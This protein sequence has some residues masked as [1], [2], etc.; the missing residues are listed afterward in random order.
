MSGAPLTACGESGSED[1]DNSPSDSQNVGGSELGTGASS[2]GG[3]SGDDGSGGSNAGGSN[4]G[5]SNAGGT[6]SDLPLSGRQCRSVSDCPADHP[7]YPGSMGSVR[8]ASPYTSAADELISGVPP[9]PDW[10]GALDC[11]SLPLSPAAAGDEC[12]SDDDCAPPSED[13]LV[14]SLCREGTC[15]VCENNDDCDGSLPFC[16]ARSFRMLNTIASLLVCAACQTHDDCGEETPFCL[17]EEGQAPRC[18]ACL[19]TSDCASGAC[20][21]GSCRPDCT[22]DDDCSNPIFGCSD[23][24]R[25]EPRS[26]S[27]DTECPSNQFCQTGVCSRISCSTDTDCDGSCVNGSCFEDFGSCA[28]TL[29]LP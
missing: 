4:A 18:V 25:C 9:Q 14:A 20:S 21:S 28:Y 23:N 12:Q 3:A 1:A 16:G 11:P 17:L 5:G 15:V 10:C 13:T 6:T 19:S 8:C 2:A 26:C 22:T 27:T 24:A 7:S 29:A